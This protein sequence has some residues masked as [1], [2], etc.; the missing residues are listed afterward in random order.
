MCLFPW[1]CPSTR[2]PCSIQKAQAPHFA[3]PALVP[4]PQQG[5]CGRK[6]SVAFECPMS[7]AMYPSFLTSPEVL[8]EK[9]QQ[10]HQNW[11]P[12]CPYSSLYFR[13]TAHHTK[14]LTSDCII[15]PQAMLRNYLEN[16]A[17]PIGQFSDVGLCR[18]FVKGQLPPDG[19]F[20]T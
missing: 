14:S 7:L 18:R 19:L 15:F 9:I 10:G 20:L 16:P 13:S 5:Q 11:N 3:T 8:L 2:E 1:G 17:L 4:A 6:A 12:K